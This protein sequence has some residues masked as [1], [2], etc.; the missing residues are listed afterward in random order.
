MVFKSYNNCGKSYKKIKAAGSRDEQLST[1]AEVPA[2]VSQEAFFLSEVKYL[3]LSIFT[4]WAF[5]ELA[6]MTSEIHF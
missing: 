5:Y 2:Y 3:T 4:V 1:L 6:L